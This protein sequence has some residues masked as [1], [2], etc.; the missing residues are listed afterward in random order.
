[1][2]CFLSIAKKINNDYLQ[3]IQCPDQ[4]VGQIEKDDNDNILV[5][6]SEYDFKTRINI[7][8]RS[9]INIDNKIIL[10]LESPHVEEFVEPYGPA[11]G[12]TGKN[13]RNLFQAVCGEDLLIGKYNL[14][15]MNA[16]QYQCSLGLPTKYYR[17]KVFDSVWEC[18]GRSNFESRINKLVKVILPPKSVHK[19]TKPH[20]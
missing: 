8:Y 17:D 13:I 16:I 4:I 5:D 19:I 15:L 14:I 1:M 7:D 2:E 10:I 3:C 20:C 11:K 6:W 18:F 9:E 12:V